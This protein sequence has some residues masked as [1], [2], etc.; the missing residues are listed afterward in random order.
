M[1]HENTRG[2]RVI[3]SLDGPYCQSSKVIHRKLLLKTENHPWD[4]RSSVCSKGFFEGDGS[5]NVSNCQKEQ[6]P[7]EAPKDPVS[8]TFKTKSMKTCLVNTSKETI[9][10][11]G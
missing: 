5:T 4:T 8:E 2:S 9:E 3:G 1:F 10:K 6:T 7:N 11:K